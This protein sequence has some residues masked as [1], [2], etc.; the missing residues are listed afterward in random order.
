[1]RL[2]LLPISTRRSL[3]YCQQ[4]INL[5][6]RQL[7]WA[8]NPVEKATAKGSET[9]LQWEKAESG[10]K[11]KVTVYGNKLFQ[12]LPFEEWGL[13][14]VPL[15]TDERKEEELLGKV[16]SH[17]VYPESL[18]KQEAVQEALRKYGSNEKQRF[19]QKWFWGSVMGMPLTM[20]AALV[21]V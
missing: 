14:S 7:T 4:G 18:L 10:W 13:K 12:R 17:V 21:P 15:L 20:P 16:K 6:P 11:K 1:M 3:I 9:W 2:F 5:S 8:H 19:H